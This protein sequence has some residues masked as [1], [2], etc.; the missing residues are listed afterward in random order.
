MPYSIFANAIGTAGDNGDLNT[1]F[2]KLK[3]QFYG[4]HIHVLLVVN[5]AAN[6]DTDLDTALKDELLDRGYIV[7]VADPADIAGNLELSYD[8]IV[9]SG[10]ITADTNLTL[11]R[12]AD[13][14]VITHSAEVAVSTN[15]FSPS[16]CRKRFLIRSS[17]KVSLFL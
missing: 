5:D 10:S 14:P 1:V 11:L 17:I 2:A 3:Q 15:V 6:L 8:F 16:I 13:C 12:E 7:V 4:T 9:V